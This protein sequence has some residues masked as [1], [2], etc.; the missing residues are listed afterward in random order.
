MDS[1]AMTAVL[2]RHKADSESRDSLALARSGELIL[3]D[4]VLLP[5]LS[6]TEHAAHYLGDH[7][8]F[9]CVDDSDRDPTLRRGYHAFLRR[10]T[11]FV[12]FDSE[13]LQPVANPGANCGGILSDAA[14]KYQCV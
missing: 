5:F 6:K 1:T 11:L 12:E 9:V 4:V 13:K 3:V 7:P 14:R 10:V 8:F 2:R